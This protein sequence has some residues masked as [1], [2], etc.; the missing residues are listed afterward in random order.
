MAHRLASARFRI[1]VLFGLVVWTASALDAASWDPASPA[2]TGHKGATLYVSK[3]GDDSDGSSWSKAFRTIQ[4]ALSAVPDDRGGHRI[5]VR[6]DRYI[7]ANLH[8]AHRGAPGAYN[9]LIGDFDGRLGSGAA[10]WVLI[11]AGDPEKGFKSW[12]WWSSFAASDKK[13][14]TGN[15]ER[16]FSSIVCDRWIFRN[17][18]AAGGDAGLF[19]DLT[20]KSG[21]G[22]TVIVEDCV[23]TGRAFGGGVCYPTVRAEE[24]TVFRRC[25]FLAFDWVGDTAAVLLGGWEKTM[26]E[27]PHAVFEDCTLVHPDNAV[28]LSYASHCAR[29]AFVDC[30]MIVLNF[31]QP[32]MGG[33]STGIICTEGHRPSGRLHVDLEDCTLA[34]YS[35]LTPGDASEACSYTIRGTVEAYVQFKQPLPDG[36]RRLGLWPADLFA[37]IAPPRSPGAREAEPR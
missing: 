36:V 19:W 28:A 15:N 32:E 27:V 34:G 14:P 20:E 2:Y 23:G 3:Q 33:R 12:D 6:P 1:P 26:P 24:P 13:W 8:P 4:A 17:L 10:G 7:E 5:F 37:R 16:T 31:T 11:D 18:Y 9:A 25:H 35:V 22:F 29:G 21:E 30:R